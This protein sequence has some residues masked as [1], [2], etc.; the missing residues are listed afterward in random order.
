MK[1]VKSGKCK[2]DG[3]ESTTETVYEF[4]VCKWHGCPCQPNRTARDEERYVATIRKEKAIKGVG[5]T[6]VIAWECEKPTKKRCYLRKGFRAYPHYIV[7]DFEALLQVMNQKQTDDP[8]YVSKHIPVSVAINDSLSE[9]ATF[10]EDEEPK[11][12]V[13]LFVEKLERRRALIL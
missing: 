5:Y 6:L 1:S 4:N 3:Y 2:V 8:V 11:I 10:I 9:S 13:Q 12:L 7:F